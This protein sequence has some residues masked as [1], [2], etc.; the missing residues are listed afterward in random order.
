M[1]LTTIP[2]IVG[3]G[4][5]GEGWRFTGFVIGVEDGNSYIAKMLSGADG[6]WLFRTPYSAEE[7]KGF[8]AFIPYILLGKL[9]SQPAQHDQLVAIYHWFR[10]FS[11]I[12]AI[13][14]GFDFI[15]LFIKDTRWKWWAL[16]IF[17]FGGGGG[18]VLVI[19]EQKNFLGSLP[20]DFISPE[21][22][23]F[24]GL[25]GFPHLALAR[26]C[27]LW[28]FTTYLKEFPG[29]VTG[30]FWFFLGFLQP[31]YVVVAWSVIGVYLI[32]VSISTWREQKGGFSGIW[33]VVRGYYARALLGVIIS[34][35]LILYSAISFIADPFL[36]TW[37]AQNSLPSPHIIHYLIAYGLY[38][39][40]LILGAINLLKNDQFKGYLIAGWLAVLPVL[41]SAPVSTQRRLAEGVWAAVTITM[42]SHFEKRNR[43][44]MIERGYLSFTFPSTI[45]IFL[46]A[47]AAAGNTAP[48]LFR[49]EPEIQVYNYLAENAPSGAVILGSYESGNNLPAWTPQRVVLGH[50][51][52]TTNRDLVE[53][54]INEFF[55]LEST[56]FYREK[57]IN[58]YNVE[59]ILWGPLEKELGAWNPAGE[60]YLIEISI[61]DDYLI[62]QTMVTN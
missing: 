25:L 13:I 60:D 41:V 51:P 14:A 30:I 31:I 44:T 36:K 34:L 10:F 38:I 18:W 24:L 8:L 32:L 11:G 54:E 15:S 27:L 16:V 53:Q 48:P 22:F 9:S 37:A 7:Q 28:G 59:Y 62:Y 5:Q 49:P 17:V 39:P 4:S 3:Y 56:D 29:Y 52:E 26:A 50:G 1:I 61:S 20:L 43:L 12:L 21:S 47:I 23:G 2:Y 33:E 45:L 55:S 40:F 46:G 6:D 19:L 57:I 42:I 35:P 58:K